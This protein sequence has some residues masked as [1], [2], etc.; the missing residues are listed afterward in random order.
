[1][2]IAFRDGP[3]PSGSIEMDSISYSNLVSSYWRQHPDY[4]DAKAHAAAKSMQVCPECIISNCSIPGL[5]TLSSDAYGPSPTLKQVR[6]TKATP[7]TVKRFLLREISMYLWLHPV[8]TK[9]KA[10]APL[11]HEY[12]TCPDSLIDYSFQGLSFDKP[13]AYIYTRTSASGG[14]L[15]KEAKVAKY[16]RRHAETIKQ[17]QADVEHTGYLDDVPAEGRQLLWIVVEDD[18]RLNAKLARTLHQTG[19][20]E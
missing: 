5:Y 7:S 10:L 18:H 20:R 4:P 14:R 16:F 2:T 3:V 12:A 19:I 9:E 17:F 11:W 8:Y 1:M 13:T 15:G 6:R